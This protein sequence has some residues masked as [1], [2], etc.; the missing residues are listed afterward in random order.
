MFISCWIKMKSL[1]WWWW[2]FRGI[3]KSKPALKKKENV[4]VTIIHEDNYFQAPSC[5]LKHP[6]VGS[7]SRTF[8]T[9]LDHHFNFTPEGWANLLVIPSC[10]EWIEALRAWLKLLR[11]RCILNSYITLPSTWCPLHAAR[12]SKPSAG[13]LTS[14]NEW[15]CCPPYWSWREGCDQ[16]WQKKRCSCI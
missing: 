2:M 16:S 1:K 10:P 5:K 9:R 15:V 14:H 8:K 13:P 6:P 11:L 7:L 3:S 4:A 12:G